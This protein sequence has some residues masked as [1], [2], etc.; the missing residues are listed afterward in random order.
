MSGYTPVFSTVFNGTLSGKW[1]TLPVWLT[2]LPLADWRGHIDM[3]PEAISGR[4]GWPIDLLLEGINELCKPDP[5]SRSQI[6]E[7]RRLV[8]IDPARDWGWRVVNIEKY[9][10]K[11]SG[12]NQVEDGRNA[13]KV[14]RYKEG[15]R[16]TPED[17]GGHRQTPTHTQ[18]QTKTKESVSTTSP[19]VFNTSGS[20]TTGN[21]ERFTTKGT[22]ELIRSLTAKKA[23]PR[24]G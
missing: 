24:G 19:S 3:T 11:A 15:H 7:G 1:P 23:L 17:T 9:R 22:G 16:R 5:R 14:R 8:L 18:T 13:E 21:P 12:R 2:I 20:L 4:T 6:E 10:D